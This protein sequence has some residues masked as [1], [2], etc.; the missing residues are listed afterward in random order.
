[1]LAT[2]NDHELQRFSI[3]QD[4]LNNKLKLRNATYILG[5]SYQHWSRLLKVFKE[6]GVESLAHGNP[7]SNRI[8][9]DTKLNVL[10]LNVLKL[11]SECYQDFGPMLVH[12]KLT[13]AHGFN[14]SLETLRQWMIADGLWVPH[15]KRKPR[16]YQSRYRRDC[17]GE[18]L[19]IDASRHDWFEGRANKCCLLVF[20]DDATGHLM[21]LQFSETEFAFDYMLATRKYLNEHG[22][23]NA[24][25]SDKNSIFRVN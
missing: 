9:D 4:V 10:K 11:I 3:I 7:S 5:I 15:S 1:M 18:L 25:Y 19:Q 14:I 2:M 16:V 12:E 20:I 24:F 6:F 13:E 23:P 8:S 21:N 17:L 22:K